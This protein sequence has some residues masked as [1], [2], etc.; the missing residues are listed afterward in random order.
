MAGTGPTMIFHLDAPSRKAPSLNEAMPVRG[1]GSMT[2]PYSRGQSSSCEAN[3]DGAT[4][5]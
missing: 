2:D 3:S 1:R 4:T 5:L